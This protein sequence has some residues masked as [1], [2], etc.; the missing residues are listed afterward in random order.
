MLSLHK[1]KDYNPRPIAR[2]EGGQ[3]DNRVIYLYD[4]E[5]PEKENTEIKIDE[6]FIQ[7]LPS[8]FTPEN[9][10]VDVLYISAKQ[11]AGKSTYAAKY[12]EDYHKLYP[13]NPIYLFSSKFDDETGKFSDDAYEDL[14]YINVIDVYDLNLVNSFKVSNFANS[15][16]IFDDIEQLP[17][18]KVLEEIDNFRRRLMTIG[19]DKGIFIIVT[20]HIMCEGAKTQLFLNEHTKGIIF[21]GCNGAQTDRYLGTYVGIKDGNLKKKILNLP[22]RWVTISQTFP[23]YVIYEKGVFLI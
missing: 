1:N 16:V 18:K 6:G 19:R 12:V 13:D 4:I 2:I 3:L 22:G 10:Q 14:E 8:L 9:K 17:E 5:N 21:K 23:P 7:P 15:L 20:S 11:G